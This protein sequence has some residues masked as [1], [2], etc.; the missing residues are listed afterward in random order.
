MVYALD[1]IGNAF[2]TTKDFLLPFG[3]YRWL[4]LTII[5]FFVGSA[6]FQMNYFPFNS[7]GGGD[8]PTTGF[9]PSQIG[10]P[11]LTIILLIIGV[12]IFIGL[13]FLVLG[14]IFE[15]ILIESLRSEQVRIRN[16][17]S[18]YWKKGL[19][20]SI[21]RFFIGFLPAIIGVLGVLFLIFTFFIAA[22]PIISVGLL[23]V[24]IPIFI[25][26]AIIF[27]II[28]GFTTNFV[29]PTMILEDCGVLAGWR[30]FWTTLKTE[31]KEYLVYLI[32]SWVLGLVGGLLTGIVFMITLIILLIPFGI[33]GVIGFALMSTIEILGIALLAI[34][35][36]FFIISVFVV[37]AFVQVPVLVYLRY[38][39]LLVLGD[40]D[41]QLD[42]IPDQRNKIK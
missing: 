5:A 38:Y 41:K 31:W 39:A 15:F 27:G 16:Y 25:A 23:F 32:L 11:E 9:D 3:L 42:I 13:I 28:D 24:L 36:L 10:I 20:L 40:T 29:V 12:I 26:I 1:E 22:S 6:G 34:V 37:S 4:K 7:F 35:V 33:L 19:R 8:T 18:K 21:F 14:S 30:R 17:W 2:E